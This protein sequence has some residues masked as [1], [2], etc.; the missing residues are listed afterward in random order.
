MPRPYRLGR[1]RAG[2]DRTS[3]DIVAAAR[4]LVAAGDP[5]S[6]TAVAVRAGVSRATVYNRFGGRAGLLRAIAPAPPPALETPAGDPTEMLR[7]AFGRS[8][9]AW[10]EKPALYRRLQVETDGAQARTLAEHLA[11][12]DALRPGCSI[13]EAEDVIA[14]LLSFPVFDRLHR[15]GRRTPG[16]V[17]DVLAR[18]AEGILA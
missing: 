4:D 13:R 16:A 7:L 2:V 5:A 14:A 15:D 9:A 1:R 12:A 3:A 11:A 8:S 17:A 10:A 18:L 6:M